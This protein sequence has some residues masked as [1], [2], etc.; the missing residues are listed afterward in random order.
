MSERLDAIVA[1]LKKYHMTHIKVE[2]EGDTGRGSTMGKARLG[3]WGNKNQSIPWIKS[4]LQLRIS[5]LDG[6]SHYDYTSLARAFILNQLSP[7][8]REALVWS[9]MWSDGGDTEM[10]FTIPA[11][12]AEYLPQFPK[13]FADL[14]KLCGREEVGINRAGM[15]MAVM[16]S[17][18]YPQGHISPFTQRRVSHY[19]TQMTKLMPALMVLASHGPTTRSFGPRKPAVVFKGGKFYAINITAKMNCFEYR[20]FDPCYD[21]PKRILDNLEVIANSLSFLDTANRATVPTWKVPEFLPSRDKIAPQGPNWRF[22]KDIITNPQQL[23]ILDQQLE[24]LK[25]AHLSIASIYRRHGL[26]RPFSIA[27]MKV[28]KPPRQRMVPF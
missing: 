24:A 27:K 17:G 3:E 4:A 22:V 10:S 18:R 15:H 6:R 16:T 14:A 11:E 20:T 26:K 25:P 19:K 21:Q 23:E 13:A 1:Q 5:S 2:M 7:K 28:V 9:G 12:A 8:A